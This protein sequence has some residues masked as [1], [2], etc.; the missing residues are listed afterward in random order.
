MLT[1]GRKGH[2][3]VDQASL[4]SFS[5]LPAPLCLGGT[6]VCIFCLILCAHVFLLLSYKL[7]EAGT[8]AGS[9]FFVLPWLSRGAVTG[10]LFTQ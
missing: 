1:A 2:M 6:V 8:M 4:P 5:S 9:F 10:N 3:S 7:P